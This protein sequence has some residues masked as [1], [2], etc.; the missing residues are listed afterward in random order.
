MEQQF[1]LH[2][3]GGLSLFEQNQMTAEERSWWLSR[4]KRAR[5]EENERIRNGSDNR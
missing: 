5:D 1:Q 2:Y 3:Y 4:V